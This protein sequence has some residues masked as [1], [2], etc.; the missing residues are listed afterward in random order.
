MVCFFCSVSPA[1]EIHLLL[2][3]A[4]VINQVLKCQAR[5]NSG[6]CQENV[7]RGE[8]FQTIEMT[9]VNIS[10]CPLLSYL[11]TPVYTHRLMLPWWAV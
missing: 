9:R 5:C 4:R 8:F 11:H 7:K 3:H 2:P 6:G 1:L 10:D